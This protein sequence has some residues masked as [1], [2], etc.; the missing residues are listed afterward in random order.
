[1]LIILMHLNYPTTGKLQILVGILLLTLKLLLIKTHSK[2]LLQSL[3]E[4]QII[5]FM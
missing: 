2:Y 4:T 3:K 5:I 1:M